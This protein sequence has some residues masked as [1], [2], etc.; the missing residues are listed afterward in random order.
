MGSGVRCPRG[1]AVFEGLLSEQARLRLLFVQTVNTVARYHHVPTTDIPDPS[2]HNPN[3][4]SHRRVLS[5]YGRF[6]CFFS[7]F[8]FVEH[9]YI[10]YRHDD[11]LKIIS[12]FIRMIVRVRIPRQDGVRVTNIE[13][14]ILSGCLNLHQI[15]IHHRFK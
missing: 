5:A 2:H 6:Q 3:I 8:L 13:I 9:I 10:L 11:W 15:V 1:R 14:Y 4:N 7:E 12:P